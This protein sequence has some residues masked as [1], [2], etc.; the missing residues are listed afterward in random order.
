MV[1]ICCYN[2]Y[3]PIQG[4]HPSTKCHKMKHGLTDQLLLKKTLITFCCTFSIAYLL[5]IIIIF[6][7][8]L[9]VERDAAVRQSAFLMKDVGND[10]KLMTAL[11]EVENTNTKMATMKTE[12]EQKVC[13]LAL[14]L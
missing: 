7:C 13:M 3:S 2:C 14:L 10:K 9:H 6:F 12:L 8:Q 11:I 1:I 5:I 4:S